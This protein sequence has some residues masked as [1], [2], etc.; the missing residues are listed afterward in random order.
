MKKRLIAILLFAAVMMTLLCSC[1]MSG[2]TTDESGK[3]TEENGRFTIEEATYGILGRTY[4]LTD[5]ETGVQYLYYMNGYGGGLTPLLDKH[6][7]P[8]TK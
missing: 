8:I 7:N 5:T 2:I 6:W 1:G 4:I 3:I